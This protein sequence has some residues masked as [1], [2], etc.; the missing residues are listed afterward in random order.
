MPIYGGNKRATLARG[1]LIAIALLAACSVPAERP[2]RLPPPIDPAAVPDAVPTADPIRDAGNTSPYEINGRTYRVLASAAGYA[3][4]GIASWYGLKF[5]GRPTANGERFS[6]YGPTAAH[7]SLPI[8]TYVRVTNLENGREMVVRVNDRGPFHDDRLI[9]LSYGA[10]LKLGF[11]DQ[12]TANVRITALSVAGVDDLRGG[13]GSGASRYLQLGAYASVEAAEALAERVR[14]AI[15]ESA[16][17]SPVETGSG[18]LYRVRLG[19]YSD[20]VQLER[21]QQ[22]LEA[23]GLPRGGVVVDSK[24]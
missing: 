3:E 4:D 15:G 1:L 22:A 19:P 12:G 7:R 17:V 23:S 9:D 20:G 16:T 21:D 14:R 11:A 6:V 13:S 2:D 8:P 24:T 5:H 10:A 18:L